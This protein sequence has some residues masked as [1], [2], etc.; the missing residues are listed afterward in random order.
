MVKREGLRVGVGKDIHP[1]ILR[2]TFATDLYRSTKNFRLTQVA[3]GHSNI[4]TT[5]I[6]THVAPVELEDAM[7]RLR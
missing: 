2:H 5:E 6:Y 7:K 1:H 4:I 3:L